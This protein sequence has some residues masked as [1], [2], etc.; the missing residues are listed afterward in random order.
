M[1]KSDCG[2]L[3]PSIPFSLQKLF[4]PRQLAFLSLIGFTTLVG[5]AGLSSGLWLIQEAIA[6]SP[7]LAYSARNTITLDWEQG[8]PY[9]SLLRRAEAAARA[10]TQRSFDSD[11][12][13]TDV[14]ITIV[15]D[16]RGSVVPVLTLEVS[17]NEW[18]TRPDPTY[19][20]TYYRTSQ[21]LLELNRTPEE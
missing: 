6:P 9:S 19:W 12:L 5:V 16:S 10:A 15:G 18:R 4:K 11:I 17:R 13:I 1:L 3:T 20:S 14:V 2:D 21:T 7:A 8:E